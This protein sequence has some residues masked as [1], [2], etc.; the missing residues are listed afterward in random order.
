[1]YKDVYVRGR[2]YME[3][4]NVNTEDHSSGALFSVTRLLTGRKSPVRLGCCL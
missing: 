4:P 2:V 3:K 1:M